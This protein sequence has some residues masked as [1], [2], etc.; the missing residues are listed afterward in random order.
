M[1]SQT[2]QDFLDAEIYEAKKQGFFG[3]P[4]NFFL[5]FIAIIIAIP[6]ICWGQGLL[7]HLDKPRIYISADIFMYSVAAVLIL[8][9]I[10][11]RLGKRRFLN[12]RLTW[13]HVCLTLFVILFFIVTH[14]WYLKFSEPDKLKA[15]FL[16]SALNNR[17]REIKLFSPLGICFLIGQLAF[18]INLF[19]SNS[20]KS[21]SLTEV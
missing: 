13:I 3:I 16:K 12:V 6:I 8:Y 2:N 14:V 9:W 7:I 15:F 17:T 21:V 19:I 4:H 1:D 20:K 5:V 10:T 18:L 11:Y